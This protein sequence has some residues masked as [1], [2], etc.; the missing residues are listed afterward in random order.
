MGKLKIFRKLAS[1]PAF[2]KAAFALH[3]HFPDICLVTGIL[4]G[5][6]G[7][8][9]AGIQTTK[10]E[11]ILDDHKERM[12]EIHKL[13]E[14][15]G[16]SNARKGKDTFKAYA[17]TAGKIAK[18]YSIP[19][20]L[21][22]IS[23]ASQMSGQSHLRAESMARAAAYTSTVEAFKAYRQHVREKEGVESDLEYMGADIQTQ[24]SENELGE[25]VTE[26][27]VVVDPGSQLGKYARI[28]DC[29]NPNWSENP[30][31]N[32]GWLRQRMTEANE[33]LHS[34]GWITLNE[35]FDLLD[36]PWT[37][38]GQYIGWVDGMGD[39][40]VDFGIYAIRN[41]NSLDGYEPAIW[42]DFN[43]D[44]DISYIWEWI[45]NSKIPGG[46]TK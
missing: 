26:K 32:V 20:L 12:D 28:F 2:S 5:I 25:K 44:G 9:S 10:L 19:V 45:K 6:G 29:G 40:Y 38:A 24:E 36:M 43:V 34:R 27:I 16:Y 11:P 15:D 3:R 14:T 33:K 17:K 39:N 22:A 21:E 31:R 23:I 18:L 8:V 35:V 1:V 4:G 7:A 46:D 37:E 13:A 42:L 30:E 41:K